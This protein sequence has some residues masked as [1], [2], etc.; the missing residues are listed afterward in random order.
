MR[1][2]LPRT[3]YV[4]AEPCTAAS[5]ARG[6][7]FPPRSDQEP[8]QDRA[9]AHGTTATRGGSY[10]SRAALWPELQALRAG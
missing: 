5:T 1:T 10:E 8:P 4:K 9:A 3:A 7:A 2:W 6:S